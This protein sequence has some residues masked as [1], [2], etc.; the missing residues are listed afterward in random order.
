MEGKHTKGQ[1]II[2]WRADSDKISNVIIPIQLDN[3]HFLYSSNTC[4]LN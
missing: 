2:D 3:V 4:L 1:V